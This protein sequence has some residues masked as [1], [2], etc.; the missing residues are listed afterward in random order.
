MLC[1][2]CVLK[3]KLLGITA[4]LDEQGTSE[5]TSVLHVQASW[6]RSEQLAELCQVLQGL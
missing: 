1:G 3:D 6:W 5:G 2:P 4:G